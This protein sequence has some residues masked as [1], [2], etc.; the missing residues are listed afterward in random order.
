VIADER[1]HLGAPFVPLCFAR[2]HCTW[3]KRPILALPLRCPRLPALP[4][5]SAPLVTANAL[6]EQSVKFFSVDRQLQPI[7]RRPH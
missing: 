7:D 6:V 2:A 4:P 3:Q 5:F 1:K